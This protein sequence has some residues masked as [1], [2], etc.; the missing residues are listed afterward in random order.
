MKSIVDRKK[1]LDDELRKTADTRKKS[2][3]WLV[4]ADRHV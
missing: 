4:R 2:P 1:T 3:M